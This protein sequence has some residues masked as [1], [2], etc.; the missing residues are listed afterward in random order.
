MKTLDEVEPRTAVTAATTPGDAVSTFMIRQPG[1]YYLTSNVVG[2]PGRHG[3]GIAANDVTLDLSGFSVV[4]TGSG[5][6]SGIRVLTT[7]TG[8]N[9]RGGTVRGW[10]GGGV[11]AASANMLAERLQLS[12]NTGAV[13]LAVGNGS[14]VRDCIATGNG[15]GFSLSDRTQIIDCMATENSDMG[16]RA[17]SFVSVLDCTASRNT[18]GGIFVDSGCSV[19]RCGTTRHLPNGFGIKTGASCSV[20]DCTSVANGLDGIRVEAGS[21]VR[22]CTVASNESRGI[23]AVNGNCHIRANTCR[24]NS[25]GIVVDGTHDEGNRIEDNSCFANTGAGYIINSQHNVV[26]ANTASGNT[27]DFRIVPGNAAGPVIDLRAGGSLA[28]VSNWANLIH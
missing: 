10:P 5:A 11:A 24:G 15:T 25:G 2:T 27:G 8:L 13:G 18:I 17:T 16:I 9:V 26:V 7:A 22:G 14:L 3:I 12:A 19:V 4:G 1:S 21:S 28:S 6:S 23:W 20:I